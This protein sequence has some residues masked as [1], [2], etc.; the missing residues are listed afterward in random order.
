MNESETKTWSAPVATITR[1]CKLY[2]GE[3]DDWSGYMYMPTPFHF[4]SI[5]DQELFEHLGQPLWKLMKEGFSVPI[6]HAECDFMSPVVVGDVLSQR[7]DLRLG[8]GTSMVML[9]EFSNENGEFVNRGKTVRVWAAIKEMEPVP[10][11]E[12]L[13]ALEPQK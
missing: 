4:M 11:P 7:I 5:G 2:A 3:G 6:I 10:L 8:Q 12:W 1:T 9:H 13:R